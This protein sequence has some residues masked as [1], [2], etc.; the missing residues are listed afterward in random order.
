MRSEPLMVRGTGSPKP[1]PKAPTMTI[2]EINT[3]QTLLPRGRISLG[4]PKKGK[5]R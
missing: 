1:G 5:L 2:K 4:S 3:L